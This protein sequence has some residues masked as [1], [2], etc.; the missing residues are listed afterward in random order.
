MF[1]VLYNAISFVISELVT[2]IVSLIGYL[3]SF[4][5]WIANYFLEL[6]VKVIE[7]PIVV[8]GWNILRDL[9]NLGFVLIIIIIAIA[10][11][12]RIEKYGAQKLLLKLIF[13]AIAINFSLT[14]AGFILNFSNVLTNFFLTAAFPANAKLGSGLSGA[15]NVQQFYPDKLNKGTG[16]A[17]IDFLLTPLFS[18]I[19]TLIILIVMIV[20][21][22]VLIYRYVKLAFL[23]IMT[24][25]AWLA[26]IFPDSKEYFQKW[27]REFLKWVFF[28]PA[29]AFYIYL[30]IKAIELMPPTF[31]PEVDVGVITELLRSAGRMIILTGLLIG[32]LMLAQQ[33]GIAGAKAV[34]E[35][36][37]KTKGWA[38][39]KMKSGGRALARRAVTAGMKVDTTTGETTSAAQRL[40]TTA[41]KIPLVGRAFR[42]IAEGVGKATHKALATEP[43]EKKYESI[44]NNDLINRANSLT[45]AAN[46]AAA[47][48]ISNQL[49]KR[50]LIGNEKIKPEKFQQLIQTV[51]KSG[52]IDTI[53][54]SMVTDLVKAVDQNVVGS[55]DKLKITLQTAREA[56]PKKLSEIYKIYP[57]LTEKPKEII[58]KMTPDEV[59]K[60]NTNSLKNKEVVTSFSEA[61][62]SAF[63]RKGSEVQREI[64]VQFF[65]DLSREIQNFVKQNSNFQR[66]LRTQRIEAGPSEEFRKAKEN[67]KQ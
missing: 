35:Q 41:T 56:A 67:Q 45:P 24:P 15:F 32:G 29:M 64:I 59:L 38:T 65:N 42:G 27:W 7:E 48:A 4:I 33:S 9:A 47:M 28:L 30:P 39:N 36:A 31:N 13:I 40:A 5:A 21:A 44:T 61:H 34:I 20:F 63:A 11:I 60:I 2:L 46:P 55:A 18:I 43:F 62:I 6:N 17:L 10:T 14:V 19:F 23:L 53:L 12:L 22:V 58:D 25:L 1:T 57:H 49:T 66:A 16:G 50:G 52:K 37:Q 26:S 8:I 3:I 51:G 54:E